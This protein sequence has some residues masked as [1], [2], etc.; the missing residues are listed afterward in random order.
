A[1]QGRRRFWGNLP[2]G[3]VD[4]GVGMV[5]QHLAAAERSGIEVRCTSPARGLLRE[6]LRVVGVLVDAPDGVDTVRGRTVVLASGGF[7]ADPRVRGTYLRPGW[8]VADARGAPS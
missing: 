4:E 5:Q 2:L 6:W 3:T 8:G 1:I 7:E